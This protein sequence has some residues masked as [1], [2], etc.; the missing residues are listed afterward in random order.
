MSLSHV[1]MR[2]NYCVVKPKNYEEVIK[3]QA[4]R[5]VMQKEIYNKA[6][7]LQRVIHN[8]PPISRRKVYRLKKTI[9]EVKQALKICYNNINNYFMDND[10]KKSKNDPTLYVKQEITRYEN[11]MV[12]LHH[13]LGIKIYQEDNEV[14]ICQK[15]YAEKIWK[16]FEMFGYNPTNTP[17]VVNEKLKKEDGRKKAYFHVVQK[18]DKLSQSS[19]K[20]EYIPI[21][22]TI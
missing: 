3:E 22:L 1:H 12:L 17:I 11:N 15:K 5:K 13:F 19:T 9:Y 10:F 14:F 2:C 7:L 20:V 4:W 6:R 8:N 21:G 18:I 16:I